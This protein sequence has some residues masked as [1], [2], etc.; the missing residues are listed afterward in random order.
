[1]QLL[2]ALLKEIIGKLIKWFKLKKR[3]LKMLLESL[4]E[5]IHSFIE[6][7]LQYYHGRCWVYFDRLNFNISKHVISYKK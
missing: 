3:N 6:K 5:E 1:M 7:I 4:K 2:A